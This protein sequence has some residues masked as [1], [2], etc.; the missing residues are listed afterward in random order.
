MR[1]YFVVACGA[2]VGASVRWG[3]G[4]V[5]DRSPDDFP[6]ATLLVNLVGCAL[7]G[8][9]IR[10][11]ARD[12]ERW[13]ALVTGVLGGLTT[14]SAFSIETRSLLDAGRP[15]VALTYVG[16]SVVGGVLAVELGRGE[17]AR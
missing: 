13:T 15:A 4:G 5:V 8:L 7:A 11:I 1:P 17:D 10:T 3:I 6:W 14:F 16:V 9:A 2:A 12:S